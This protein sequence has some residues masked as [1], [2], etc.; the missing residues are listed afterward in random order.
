MPAIDRMNVIGSRVASQ[1]QDPNVIRNPAV[2]DEAA[3]NEG[4][5]SRRLGNDRIESVNRQFDPETARVDA[6]RAQQ[7]ADYD[8]E[9]RAPQREQNRVDMVGRLGVRGQGWKNEQDE[10]AASGYFN[11]LT[12]ARRESEQDFRAGIAD[13][14]YGYSADARRHVGDVAADA[15]VQAAGITANGR[16]ND[17][18][19]SAAARRTGQLTDDMGNTSPENQPLVRNY[20]KQMGG[21]DGKPFPVERFRQFADQYFGGDQAAAEEA[22]AAEGYYLDNGR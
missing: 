15:K 8:L 4:L 9:Y 5:R 3:A 22:I 16:S 10:E 18:R 1:F 17:A 12:K 19:T 21:L 14:Q 7:D 2:F 6:I 11:P 13:R 20:D